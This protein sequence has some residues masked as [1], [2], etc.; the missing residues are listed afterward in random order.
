M[1][2]RTSAV[3]VEIASP[4]GATGVRRLQGF[5]DPD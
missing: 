3:V 4:E 5:V 2:L 1:R